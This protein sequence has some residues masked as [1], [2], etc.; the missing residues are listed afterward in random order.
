M[1]GPLLA[2]SLSGGPA[3]F[4][5]P[6]LAPA[7]LEAALS[8]WRCA[9]AKGLLT[10]ID[11]SLPSTERR[12]WVLDPAGRRVLFHDLVAHGK[13]SGD[14]RATAF[15][16]EPK[17]LASSLGVFRTGETYR[18]KHGLSLKLEGLEQG[19]NARAEERAVVIHG[20]GY[21]SEAFARTHGRLGR[22]WGCPAVGMDVAAKL[23]GAIA[24]GSLVVAW[25]PD[26]RWLE[27]SRFLRCEGT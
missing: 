5:P 12:L 18:G 13:G 26:E 14:D 24:G 17:S 6:G 2:L 21:V 16:D 19:W 7:A 1:L 23:I 10:V 8:A 3:G 9:G 11:Y 15:S 25:Y 22:S 27:S 4:H 20:A